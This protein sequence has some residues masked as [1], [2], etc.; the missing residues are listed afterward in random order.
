MP[1][2]QIDRKFQ[3]YFHTAKLSMDTWF[4]KGESV[5]MFHP[6]DKK[7]SFLPI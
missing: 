4:N 5:E 1:I 6:F 2:R 3:K 7:H